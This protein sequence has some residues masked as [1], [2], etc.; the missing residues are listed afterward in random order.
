MVSQWIRLIE[1][2][3]FEITMLMITLDSRK[4]IIIPWINEIKRGLPAGFLEDLKMVILA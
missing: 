3:Y 1:C 2:N 4:I